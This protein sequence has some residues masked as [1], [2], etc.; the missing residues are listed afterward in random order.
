MDNDEKLQVINEFLSKA[1]SQTV[2]DE[3]QID[4]LRDFTNWLYE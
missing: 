1:L 2:L 4:E 3:N